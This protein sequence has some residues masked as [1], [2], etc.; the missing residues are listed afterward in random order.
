LVFPQQSSC[1]I[2][3]IRASSFGQNEENMNTCGEQRAALFFSFLEMINISLAA[4]Q[5][6][7][8]YK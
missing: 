5:K 8:F 3:L 2:I 4:F 6:F 1:F 7:S